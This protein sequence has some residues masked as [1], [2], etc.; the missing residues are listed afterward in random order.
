MENN[1]EYPHGFKLAAIMGSSYL[2]MFL[3]AL[4]SLLSAPC[5]FS[6][7]L[8]NSKQVRLIVTIAVPEI[9]DN[10]QSITNVGWYGSAYLLTNCAF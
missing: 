5:R 10:F 4:V 3:V 2:S 8:F 7:A 9:T 6:L 1:I